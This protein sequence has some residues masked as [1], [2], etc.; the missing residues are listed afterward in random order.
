MLKTIF[1]FRIWIPT[2]GSLFEDGVFNIIL[3][4]SEDY[5]FK[6]PRVRF[7]SKMFHPNISSDGK[8]PIL[9]HE[10]FGQ[11][12]SPT[13]TVRDILQQIRTLLMYPK[14]K[15]TAIDDTILPMPAIMCPNKRAFDLINHNFEECKR[16]VLECVQNS[17]SDLSEIQN[18][19]EKLCPCLYQ[20]SSPLRRPCLRHPCV[21][22][23]LPIFRQ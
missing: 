10:E 5:P 9:F 14:I 17:L 23:D 19:E 4:F 8:I 3:V 15:F 13:M 2:K 7:I 6:S 16:N 21:S 12:W 20:F 1:I 11:K 18:L 22:S